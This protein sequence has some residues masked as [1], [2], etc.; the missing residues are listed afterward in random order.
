M[1]RIILVRHGRTVLNA[2]DRLRGLADPEL[3]S[4]GIDQAE[5]VAADITRLR[6][7]VVW[8]SPL[9]RAVRTA[10]II[11]DASGVTHHVDARLND[12]D[13]G[14]WTGELR[15]EVVR[16]FGRVDA[17]PGVEPRSDVFERVWPAV[18]DAAQTA[19][20][21][22]V[23]LVSHDAVLRPILESI[24]GGTIDKIIAPGSCH[25]V[26]ED[27]DR[28]MVEAMDWKADL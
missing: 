19:A 12:R 21:G 16:R 1:R 5:A 9:R 3:D 2:E 8:S 24:I 17:A 25:I 10:T 4:V 11:A 23:V 26:S 22:P 28:W 18:V 15:S 7:H 13:Y 20:D 6:P 27:D 14:E